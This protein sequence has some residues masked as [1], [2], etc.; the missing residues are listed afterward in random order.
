MIDTYNHLEKRNKNCTPYLK[1]RNN[2]IINV[3]SVLF[4]SSAM[5]LLALKKATYSHRGDF[6]ATTFEFL[7]LIIYN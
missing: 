7:R 2:I 6:F 3:Q 1:C 5:N 4:C